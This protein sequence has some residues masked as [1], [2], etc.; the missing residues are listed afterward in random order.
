VAL[1]DSSSGCYFIHFFEWMEVTYATVSI[2]CAVYERRFGKRLVT[3]LIYPQNN[4]GAP[5]YNKYGVYMVKLW[6][7]AVARHML[8]DD[9]LSV[10]RQGTLLCSSGNNRDSSLEF[11]FPMFGR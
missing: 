8:V 2:F 4:H 10:D 11:R 1:L 7:I 6:L 5:I 3:S 9:M